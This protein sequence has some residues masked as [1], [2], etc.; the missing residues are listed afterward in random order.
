MPAGIGFT[1]ASWTAYMIMYGV[2][3]ASVSAGS[4]HLAASVTCR[5][6]RSSPSVASARDGEASVSS[7]SAA[8]TARRRTV[9]WLMGLHHRAGPVGNQA[10][11]GSLAGPLTSQPFEDAPIPGG[12]EGNPS[13]VPLSNKEGRG[14][15]V[16]GAPSRVPLPK[17]AIHAEG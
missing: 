13:R 7:A 8:Q 3:N 9:F 14:E 1:S 11:A 16:E 10:T 15:P 5:P 2:L 6:Q 12:E 4:S 17:G